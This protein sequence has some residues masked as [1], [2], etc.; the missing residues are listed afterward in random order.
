M[1]SVKRIMKKILTLEDPG[2]GSSCRSLGASNLVAEGMILVR[3][4][5]SDTCSNS[6]NLMELISW[7]SDKSPVAADAPRK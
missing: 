3:S 1:M 4:M 6:K 5:P 7:A 2:L